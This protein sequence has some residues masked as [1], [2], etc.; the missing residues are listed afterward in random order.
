MNTTGHI[1]Q[2]HKQA[3]LRSFFSSTTTSFP[4]S[5]LKNE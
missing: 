2:N 5:D 3:Y 1:V 4:T